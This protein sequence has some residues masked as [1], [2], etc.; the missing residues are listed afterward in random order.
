MLTVT[1]ALDR[2]L[3]YTKALGSEQV[4]L[5]D[6]LG[7]YLHSDIVADIDNPPFDNSAVDG[8]AVLSSDIRTASAQSPVT[9]RLL[10][11]V[12]AG[13]G[14]SVAMTSGYCVRTMT[15]A[16]IPPG[17]DA[18]VMIEDAAE[19]A[20]NFIEFRLPANAG[21]NIRLRGNDVICGEVV[22]RSGS[23]VNSASISML[24]AMGQSKV[25]CFRR[26]RVAVFSSG[27]EL[28][29][30]DKTPEFGKIRD[31]NRYTLAAMVLS[32]GAE[33]LSHETIP[34]SLEE[35]I[36]QLEL[37]V[38]DGA[39][40]IITSGGV[41]VGDRDYIKPAIEKLGELNLWRVSMKPGKPLA[42]GKI[43]KSLLF[44]LPGNPVSTQVTFELF[45]RPALHK[46]S[47]CQAP[48]RQSVY[49]TLATDLERTPG[50][51]EYIRCRLSTVNGQ[52]V[53]DPTGPQG[54]GALKSM[55]GANA[56]IIVPSETEK[57]SINE[58]VTVMPL[59]GFFD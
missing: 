23:K 42:F 33:L 47:G 17:A 40:V 20:G 1:E 19:S 44:G 11:P 52:Y 27:D 6:S 25:L 58:L 56:L 46:M 45:V 9:L 32:A 15:G 30:I 5:L 54:S 21:D 55:V 49:A 4:G 18:M 39:D 28:V 14:Q 37:A 59:D 48:V 50:R 12:F 41:S 2:I 57:M 36:F 13:G 31:S 43:E 35:T 53:A 34:D 51:Q 29:G 38:R 3:A 8:F 26:P 16:P 24:A 22:L 7:R 10:P